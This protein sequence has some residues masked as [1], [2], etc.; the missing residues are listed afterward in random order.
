MSI[1]A[2]YRI[3]VR[4]LVLAAS[5][6][7]FAH[8]HH[9]KQRIRVNVTLEA[10]IDPAHPEDALKRV[11]SYGDIVAGTQALVADTHFNLAETLAERIAALSLADPRAVRVTV[12]VEKLDVFA[13]AVVG[14]EIDRSRDP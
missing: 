1:D 13:G 4:D 2:P 5:I 6:G 3:L 8:E 10:R 7:A 12:R 9:A 11:I 14:V